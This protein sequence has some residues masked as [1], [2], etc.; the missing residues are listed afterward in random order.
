MLDAALLRYTEFARAL[1]AAIAA[2]SGTT[3][4]A[5][6]VSLMAPHDFSDHAGTRSGGGSLSEPSTPTVIAWTLR[7]AGDVAE[8]RCRTIGARIELDLTMSD[9]VIVSQPCSGPDRA[10][11]VSNVWRKALIQCGWRADAR[12]F[13]RRHD[14]HQETCF[15]SDRD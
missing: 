3:H 8:C 1:P 6:T 2:G 12:F 7:R 9:T 10:A 13:F 4:Q 14:D 15:S 5:H 11:F